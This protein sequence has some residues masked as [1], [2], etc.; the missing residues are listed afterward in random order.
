[1]VG[2]YDKATNTVTFRR[3][4][5]VRINTVVKSLKD[6][7]GVKE[8]DISNR[9]MEARNEL[10]EKFG[11]KKRKAQIRAEERNKINMDQIQGSASIIST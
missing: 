1:M 4:P 5:L 6:S 9:I 7:R 11:N 8:H 2:V 3:A 10:G